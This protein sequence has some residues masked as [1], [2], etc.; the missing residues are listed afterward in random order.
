MPS[1]AHGGGWIP[2]TLPLEMVNTLRHGT[3]RKY[4]SHWRHVSKGNCG[5]PQLVSVLSQCTPAR[6]SHVGPKP[7]GHQS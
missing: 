5:C 2:I 7:Q 6:M 3:T 4:V 1:Q